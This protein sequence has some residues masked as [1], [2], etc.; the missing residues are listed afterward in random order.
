MA[1]EIMEDAGNSGGNDKFLS[2]VEQMKILFAVQ[3]KGARS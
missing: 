2:L 3:T 1:R